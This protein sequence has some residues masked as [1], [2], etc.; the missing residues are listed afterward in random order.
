MGLQSVPKEDLS[1]V[2]QI[3]ISS[4]ENNFHRLDIDVPDKTN[5]NSCL[6]SYFEYGRDAGTDG[7]KAGLT[8]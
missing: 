5:E 3:D 7:G 6:L 4:S 8:N 2:R 1:S